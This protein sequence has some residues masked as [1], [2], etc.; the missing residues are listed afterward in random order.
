MSSSE[1]K[2]PPLL[3]N[4]Y[5]LRNS[6]WKQF[7]HVHH[8]SE[9]VCSSCATIVGLLDILEFLACSLVHVSIFWLNKVASFNE[10]F[11]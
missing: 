6:R 7:S 4:L 2:S 3:A 5:P 8:S 10:G 11:L 1:L 9:F